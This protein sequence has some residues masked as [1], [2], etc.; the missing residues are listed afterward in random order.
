MNWTVKFLPEALEDFEKLDGS[1]KIPVR[2]AITKVASNPVSIYEGG[3]GHPLSN[4]SNTKLAGFYKIKLKASGIRIV[5][6]LIKTDADMLIVVI[7]ARADNEV[8]E[9]ADKR[10]KKNEL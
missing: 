1:N 5:Y 2:K 6:K 9:L 8:Y 4:L 3:Y 7:G 10:I